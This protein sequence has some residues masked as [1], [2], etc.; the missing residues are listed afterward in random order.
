[1]K[2]PLRLYI[3]RI[4]Y[5]VIL[6]IIINHSKD[7]ATSQPGFNGMSFQGFVERWL[8]SLSNACQ[9]K[10]SVCCQACLGFLP[11][12]TFRA[13]TNGGET[14]RCFGKTWDP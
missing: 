4:Y 9:T 3:D 13:F 11:G 12:G 8:M 2:S 10:K 1:M 14:C 5:P 6:G 7:P